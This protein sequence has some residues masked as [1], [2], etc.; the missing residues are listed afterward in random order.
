MANNRRRNQAEVP[1]A[2]NALDHLK[3]E[4]ASELGIQNYDQIDKGNLPSRV[5]GYVGGV[6]VRKMIEFAEEAMMNNGQ[7][8]QAVEAEPGANP[9][10]I[11]SAQ[12]SLAFA[13]RFTNVLNMTSGMNGTAGT[14]G[15]N[16]MAGLNGA[17]GVDQ[18]QLLH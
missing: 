18:Q 8:L 7:V 4:V 16:G 13:N 9:N 10:E 15:T 12:Q 6:M 3:T 14:N 5:N 17:G 11:Q 1:G 2:R